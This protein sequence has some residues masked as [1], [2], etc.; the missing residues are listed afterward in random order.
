MDPV[1]VKVDQYSN[2]ANPI[3][4]QPVAAPYTTTNYGVNPGY[5]GTT[6]TPVQHQPMVVQSVPTGYASGSPNPLFVQNGRQ[7]PQGRWGDSICDWPTNLFPSCYCVCCFCC[8][9]YL[10][11]QIAQKVGYSSFRSVLLAFVGFCIFGFILELIIG[12]VWI[13]WI[14]MIFAFCFA[15]GLRLFIVS[16]EGINE[17]GANPCLG[18]C[19]V[20][21]WCW[22]CSV[23]QMARHVYGYSKVFDGD[24]DPFRPD[25]YSGAQNV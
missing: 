1:Q 3:A 12:G 10:A 11:A 13:V 15:L 19:C 14:P 8:G 2:N 22:Y 4:A 18:E 16:K 24:G 21:F 23:A 7:Y 6:A 9:M 20:G 5:S 17:C 25:Q